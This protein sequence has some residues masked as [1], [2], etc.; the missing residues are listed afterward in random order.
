MILVLYGRHAEGLTDADAALRPGRPSTSKLFWNTSHIYAQLAGRLTDESG[1][2]K[3]GLAAQHSRYLDK[4]LKLLRE[5][6]KLEEELKRAAAFWQEYV[7]PDKLLDPV[8]DSD[9]F[10]RLGA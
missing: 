6:L 1:R 3:V 5:A 9:E 10:Q 4:S 8:R 2:P 7:V